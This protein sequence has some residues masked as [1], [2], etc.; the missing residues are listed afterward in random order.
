MGFGDRFGPRNVQR[1]KMPAPKPITIKN[2]I[3]MGRTLLK[4][5]S[6]NRK[7]HMPICKP[8]VILTRLS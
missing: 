4:E 7:I 8:N 2:K 5:A 6:R 3:M 1:N